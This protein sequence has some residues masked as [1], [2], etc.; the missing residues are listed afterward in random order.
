MK[1]I[2]VVVLILHC[3]ILKYKN[4]VIQYQNYTAPM[5]SVLSALQL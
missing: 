1:M 5:H 2:I 3:Y 4:I